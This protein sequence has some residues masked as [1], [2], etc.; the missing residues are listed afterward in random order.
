MSANSRTHFEKSSE[1]SSMD[2][3]I[4]VGQGLCRVRRADLWARRSPTK[5]SEARATRREWH[6]PM[7]NPQALLGRLRTNALTRGT[8]AACPP[9]S[10]VSRRAIAK[11]LH[12]KDLRCF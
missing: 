7:P 2:N 8:T 12:P 1:W 9:T 6:A 5:E 10:H 4:I 3:L 11:N